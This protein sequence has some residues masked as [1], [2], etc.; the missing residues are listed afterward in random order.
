MI[1]HIT[2]ELWQPYCLFIH[3]RDDYQN[4]HKYR[5]DFVALAGSIVCESEKLIAI[6]EEVAEACMEETL[7]NVNFSQ[8]AHVIYCDQYVFNTLQALVHENLP[9][10]EPITQ[11]FKLLMKV[12]ESSHEEQGIKVDMLSTEPQSHR[13]ILSCTPS[14]CIGYT[15]YTHA[16]TPRAEIEAWY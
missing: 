2:Q 8:T 10:I 3:I 4:M 1:Y 5:E 9:K 12:M 6:G 15:R 11:Q 14:F 16:Q 7:K 13:F